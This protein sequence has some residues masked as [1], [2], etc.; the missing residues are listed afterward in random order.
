VAVGEKKGGADE[1]KNTIK[2]A[3]SEAAKGEELGKALA[4]EPL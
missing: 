3:P 2:R 1:N 4:G